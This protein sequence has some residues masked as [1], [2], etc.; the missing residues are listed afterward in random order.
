MANLT[1]MLY[2]DETKFSGTGFV[3]FQEIEARAILRL[4]VNIKNFGQYKKLY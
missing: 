3:S 4:L 2:L 1:K